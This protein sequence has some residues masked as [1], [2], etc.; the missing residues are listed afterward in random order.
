MLSIVW[1]DESQTFDDVQ[2]PVIDGYFASE[3]SVAGGS[4][5]YNDA[6]REETVTYTKLGSWIPHVPDLP[7]DEQLKTR[8]YPNDPNDASKVWTR[9]DPNYVEVPVPY[10]PG[11]T[12]TSDGSSV[13][14]EQ[15]DPNDV[16]KGYYPP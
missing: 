11:Y 4:V 2:T 9:D 1:P 8:V 15:I 13:P 6:S 7:E 5:D 12:P 16:T 14:L 10:I 3:G